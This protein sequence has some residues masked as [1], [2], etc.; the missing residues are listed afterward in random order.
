MKRALIYLS[1]FA[2]AANVAVFSI[3]YLSSPL[4]ENGE[5]N[6][7]LVVG[8]VVVL[9]IALTLTLSLAASIIK[10][11][12]PSHKLPH[13]LIRDSLIMSSIVSLGWIGLLVLQ[14]LRAATAV[15]ILLW[16]TIVIASLWI[17][18]SLQKA[19]GQPPTNETPKK[20]PVLN[21]RRT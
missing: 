9:F 14:L 4:S 13:L 6:T 20:L 10:A 15:N 2:L 1:I 18:R 19:I 12:M 5:A 7:G 21:R 17:V 8:F 16:L 3:A 11:L